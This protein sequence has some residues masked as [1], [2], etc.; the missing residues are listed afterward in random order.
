MDA[1][2]KARAY[3]ELLEKR[4]EY[5]REYQR[6]YRARIKARLA[7]GDEKETAKHAERQRKNLEYQHRHRDKHLDEVNKRRRE[8]YQARKGRAMDSA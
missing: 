6:L 8:R 7:E 2:E 1:E 4:R 3:D 5:N